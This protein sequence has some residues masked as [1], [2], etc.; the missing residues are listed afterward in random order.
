MRYVTDDLWR[1]VLERVSVRAQRVFRTTCCQTYHLGYDR[2]VTGW[3]GRIL[4]D[5]PMGLTEMAESARQLENYLCEAAVG[6]H[7]DCVV[8][9]WNYGA[10][11]TALAYR[12]AVAAGQSGA[13]L[14]TLNGIA[15]WMYKVAIKYR[16]KP[17]LMTLLERKSPVP[18]IWIHRLVLAR[19]WLEAI[20]PVW[21]YARLHDIPI[22]PEELKANI[23]DV[24]AIIAGANGGEYDDSRVALWQRTL[25][26][27]LGD[28]RCLGGG[29][30]DVLRHKG[31]SAGHVPPGASYGERMCAARTR[32]DFVEAAECA[33]IP[34][35]ASDYYK[36]PWEHRSL[37][38]RRFPALKPAAPASRMTPVGRLSYGMPIEVHSAIAADG[39]TSYKYPSVDAVFET[40]SE[41]ANADPVD[42]TR[43]SQRTIAR[44]LSIL[45]K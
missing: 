6:G 15:P 29:A 13:V 43:M 18:A 4:G 26:A 31:I 21:D 1:L 45:R 20:Q 34:L 30:D 17:A 24:Q 22:P 25:A 3:R 32:Q 28:W 36:L 41:I 39:V 8:N 35:G 37:L 12:M 5:S 23:A 14:V 10:N 11:L 40:L 9:A 16:N 27:R 38:N 33:T 19:G 44:Y 42:Y 7:D 2:L